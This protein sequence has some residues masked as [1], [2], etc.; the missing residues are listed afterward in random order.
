LLRESLTRWIGSSRRLNLTKAQTHPET[1]LAAMAQRLDTFTIALEKHIV[2]GRDSKHEPERGRPGFSMGRRSTDLAGGAASSRPRPG[3]HARPDPPTI[4]WINGSSR[5]VG[6]AV[7]CCQAITR[8]SAKNATMARTAPRRPSPLLIR[9]PFP[10]V[11]VSRW[12]EKAITR[13]RGRE[14][15]NLPIRIS[16]STPLASPL[17]SSRC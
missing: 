8:E 4:F 16:A 5:W 14:E 7:S 17:R 9:M 12:K 1:R 13:T 6:R 15:K 11:F 10:R 3:S 2:E